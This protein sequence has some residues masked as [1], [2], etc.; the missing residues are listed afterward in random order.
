MASR[1]KKVTKYRRPL[2]INIG[3]IIFGIIFI[4][5]LFSII[6]YMINPHISVYEVNKGSLS[7]NNTY[8][9]LI[10]RQETKITADKAG[11]VN[12]YAR[13]G[14]K[15]GVGQTVYTLDETGK[16]ADLLADSTNS[17]STLTD[18]D[19][20]S[21][22]TE[23]SSFS[24]DFDT[25]NFKS[26]YN[27]KYDIENTVLELVN[28]NLLNSISDLTSEN[29]GLFTTCTAPSE[30]LVVYSTD[31]YEDATIDNLTEDMLNYDNYKKT[32][33]KSSDLV[34]AGDVVYKLITDEAWS[35]VIPLDEEKAT[36][37]ADRE[38]MK[39][40]F[41]KDGVIANAGFSI[42]RINSKPYAKLDL[43]NSCIRYATDRFIDIELM[44]SSIEGLK[45]PVSSVVEK[46]FYTIPIDYATQ[47]G[48]S[49]QLGFLLEV[50]DQ[51]GKS[52]TQFV[53]P[54]IYYS[55]DDDYYVET[56]EFEVGNYIVKT[57]STDRYPIGKTAKL[58]GV[59]NINKGYA[60]FKQIN[61]LYQ[62]EEYDIVEEGTTYGI[63]VYDH[64][65]LDGN[66]VN[67]DDIIY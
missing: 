66:S 26:V 63:A 41:K 10:L 42:I 56:H 28:I 11:Y 55:T 16:L 14:E 27:F 65:V 12:F 18:D 32:T 58:T 53:E 38:T 30:G 5:V 2:N 34:N 8:Q 35:I 17:E 50:Y 67:E 49:N 40:K 64:I 43:T 24:N 29:A 62:N 60:V 31:G 47:G 36:E 39:I 1:N 21:L 33:L 23:I 15:I 37:Y 52:S 4:Y 7:T 51:D 6:L 59:Y 25:N 46:D 54:T 57:D 13:E 61:V 44:V 9:G 20:K 19:I 48:D 45:I 3:I 22:K